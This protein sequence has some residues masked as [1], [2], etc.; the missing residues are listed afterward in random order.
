MF[1]AMHCGVFARVFVAGSSD[2]MNIDDDDFYVNLYVQGIPLNVELDTG[3]KCNI[4]SL[5][6]L[7]N[8]GVSYDLK[9]SKVHISG[10]HGQ[11][12]QAAG[13]VSLL[14][15][16]KDVQTHVEFQVLDGP[17]CINLLGR[18]DC[19]RFGL[20]ARVNMVVTDSSCREI[21]HKYADV[22]GKDIG[23]LPGEYDIKV[24][25]S[26][27]PVIHAPRSV[28]SALRDK[29]KDELHQM[30]QIGILAKVTEPTPW[31]NSMVVVSKK[32]NNR[33]RICIDPSDL[34][35]AILREHYPMNTIDDIATRLSGSK[36]FTT[37]D[38]NMGYFQIKLT[39]KSSYLTTFNTPFGRFRYLRMPMGASCSADRFQSAMVT[40][41]EGIEGVE[42]V[43][44]DI[45]IHGKTLKEHNERLQKVLQKCRDINLKLNKRKCHI[46][47]LEVKY[48]GHKLTV[49]GIKP[50][51]ERV[52]A[53]V[54][55]REP[56]DVKEL[57]S[58]LGMVAYVAKFIPKLSE[59]NAPLR[60]L[61][62]SENWYWGHNEQA[63][64]D[65]IKKELSSNRVLKY[66]DVNKPILLSVDAS[67]R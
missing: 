43:V 8:L 22:F 35:K 19:V 52:E 64:F 28:P 13:C 34:N 67:S 31:V 16:Y 37:L 51:D 61:K 38:A 26:F 1:D 49:D 24:D 25:E 29:V 58:V 32:D 65:A 60:D 3:A 5:R 36:Y 2:K 30:E 42:V 54:K 50:T 12:A 44:D 48:V 41:F 47:L 33:V 17:K 55:M 40:A 14:C 23:C 4:L 62:K 66:Y 46:G 6:T 10:V 63:A 27:P 18:A 56:R 57:E 39:D 53:I 21:V 59:L 9:P 20:I 45:L 7:K 15:M 11:S